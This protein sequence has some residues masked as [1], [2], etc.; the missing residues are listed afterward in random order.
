VLPPIAEVLHGKTLLLTG[1]TGLLGKVVLHQLILH[2]PESLR[3]ACLVRPRQNEPAEDRF[4]ARVLGSEVFRPLRRL[5]RRIEELAG[6]RIA[7]ISGDIAERNLGLAPEVFHELASCLD[8]IINCAAH[9]ELDGPLDA[10]LAANTAGPDELIRFALGWRAAGRKTAPAVV[11]V[12]TAAVSGTRSGPIAEDVVIDGYPRREE[13]GI[14][15]F[16]GDEMQALQE[17]VQRIRA[18]VG[19]QS[20]SAERWVAQRLIA[21]GRTRAEVWGWPN[22]HTFTKALGERAV[23]AQHADVPL[24]I[25]RPAILGAA[26]RDPMP[27]WTEA[28]GPLPALALVAWRGQRFYPI[29]RQ[30]VIDVMPVDFAANA[31]IVI[32]ALT[33]AGKASGVY[34]LTSGDRNALTAEAL[35]DLTAEGLG[36]ERRRVARGAWRKRL[37]LPLRN[38]IVSEQ[39]YRRYSAPARA[40]WWHRAAGLLE[41]IPPRSVSTLGA[42]RLRQRERSARDVDAILEAYRSIF[43]TAQPIYTADRTH[44]LYGQLAPDDRDR[45][46]F[47]PET[48]DWKRH[49]VDVQMNGVV[50]HA[51]P[52]MGEELRPLN[53]DFAG[54]SIGELLD[55]SAGRHG[56]EIALEIWSP[57]GMT[58][59]TYRDLA[60]IVSRQARDVSESIPPIVS[61]VAALVEEGPAHAVLVQRVVELSGSIA[62]TS[63]DTVLALSPLHCKGSLAAS[64]LLPL[65]RGA[66][67]LCLELDPETAAADWRSVEIGFVV[68]T[69]ADIDRWQSSAA[70]F[71]PRFRGFVCCDHL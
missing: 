17:T 70:R 3:I 62:L 22:V 54:E 46:P 44:D 60:A 4:R 42:S 38:R 65:A 26:V 61:R 37:R 16:P 30:Q 31:T 55:S 23:A 52:L 27:G 1:V 6:S 11:H 53:P 47:S 15:F 41:R 2:G 58:Q 36:R 39:T 18:E 12:S 21:E 10:A 48:I 69:A 56:P 20:A 59:W 71:G 29:R 25:V 43:S 35:I 68:G 28:G 14:Q 32:G 45:Y 34:H 13:L 5:G 19:L 57:R 50:Q 63:R 66:R 9:T 49:W 64:V 67:V 33:L 51:F 7:V 40:K 8:L 24:S